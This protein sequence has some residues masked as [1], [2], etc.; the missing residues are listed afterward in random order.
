MGLQRFA[1][2]VV[3]WSVAGY[4]APWGQ[5][6]NPGFYL[7]LPTEYMVSEALWSYNDVVDWNVYELDKEPDKTHDAETDGCG[8]GNL[9]KFFSIWLGTSLD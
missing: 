3:E 4:H 6:V 7:I 8:D 5:D 1:E 2:C 9:L